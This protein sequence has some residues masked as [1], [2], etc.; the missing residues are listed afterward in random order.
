M[1]VN[2][3][4]LLTPERAI[5]HRATAT[6]IVADMHLGYCEAR[7]GAGEAVPTV[8]LHESLSIFELL[9]SR[10]KVL[11]VVVA[12]DLIENQAGLE[13]ASCFHRCLRRM[14][15]DLTVVPGNHDRGLEKASVPVQERFTIGGWHVI[16]GSGPLPRGRVIVGHYHP[17]L[18]VDGRLVPCFLIGRRRMILPAFS[19]DATGGRVIS[20]RGRVLRSRDRDRTSGPDTTTTEFSLAWSSGCAEMGDW[21]AVAIAGNALV[22]ARASVKASATKAPSVSYRA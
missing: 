14:Q 6:A 3:E 18:R 11:R 5:V 22:S 21:Q 10:H 8:A 15:I 4:W 2:K 12:G 20:R 1:L 9:K 13:A 19:Q 7:Q 16:H 17:A